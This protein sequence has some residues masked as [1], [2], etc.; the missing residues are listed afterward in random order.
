MSVHVYTYI[1]PVYM[2][3]LGTCIYMCMYM[4]NV[5]TLYVY[6]S[7]VHVFNICQNL[8]EKPSQSVAEHFAAEMIHFKAVPVSQAVHSFCNKCT[9]YYTRTVS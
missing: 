6:V 8:L 3:F 1:V 7:T 5:Y 4:Y 2:Y 9:T